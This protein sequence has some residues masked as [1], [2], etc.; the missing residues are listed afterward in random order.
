MDRR[1]LETYIDR[2]H[3]ETRKWAEEHPLTLT[4]PLVTLHP[5]RFKNQERI[6]YLLAMSNINYPVE[7]PG[8][9]SGASS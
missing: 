6:S 8:H 9:D 3:E 4:P 7:S 5:F 2:I 1:Q